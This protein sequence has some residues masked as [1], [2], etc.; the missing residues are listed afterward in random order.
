[1]KKILFFAFLSFSA[2]TVFAETVDKQELKEL[3]EEAVQ[4][5]GG[6]TNC[7]CSGRNNTSCQVSCFQQNAICSRDSYND[8]SCSCVRIISL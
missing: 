1:M 4:S 7:H 5:A 6:V 3:I 2:P 8:C